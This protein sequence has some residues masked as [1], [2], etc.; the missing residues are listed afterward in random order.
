MRLPVLAL[1]LCMI[2]AGTGWSDEPDYSQSSTEMLVDQLMLIDSPAPGI[3]GTGV[4]ETFIGEPTPLEF[5]MGILGVPPPTVP[6][7]MRELVRRGVAAL[8]V[9][10]GH[11]DDKRP[12]KLIV[13]G[14][15]FDRANFYLFEIF[16]TEY[17]PRRSS[18]PDSM[19]ER[20]FSGRYTVKVGDICYVLIGQIVNRNLIAVRY[21]PTA[22]LIVNSPIEQPSLATWT[23]SDWNGLDAAEHQASLL[24]DVRK[25]DLDFHYKPTLARLRFYYPAAYQALTGDDRRKRDVFEGKAAPEQTS[26]DPGKLDVIEGQGADPQLP[27]L[28]SG[29]S[30]MAFPASPTVD[31]SQQGR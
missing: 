4:Y 11:L 18:S 6:P 31:D 23:R 13:G 10:L 19:T 20:D 24:E 30:V 12:T 28:P 2:N 17:A 1:A 5:Q 29:S 15:I 25:D 9:L 26:V 7:Q 3:D 22:G 16:A 8:P 27:S 14:S 21:Q